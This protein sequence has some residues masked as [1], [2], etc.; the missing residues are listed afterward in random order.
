MPSTQAPTA[1]PATAPMAAPTLDQRV[2]ALEL[3]MQHL[4]LVVECETHFTAE[5]LGR[6]MDIARERMRTTGSTSSSTERAL[7]SLQQSV[8]GTPN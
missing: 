7:A 3:F 2:E 1:A 8:L 4:V 5:A 6:W